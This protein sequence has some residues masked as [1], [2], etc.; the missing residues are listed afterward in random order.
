M[1]VEYLI[2]HVF[3][4]DFQYLVVQRLKLL[5]QFTI[6]G[7]YGNK[8]I[9]QTNNNMDLGRICYWE[10]FQAFNCRWGRIKSDDYSYR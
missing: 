1:K 3:T 8:I 4:S 5:L 7:K 10:L 9:Y 2:F 6:T